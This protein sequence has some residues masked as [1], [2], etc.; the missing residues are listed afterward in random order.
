MR[1]KVLQACTA[2]FEALLNG[3]TRAYTKASS[4]TAYTANCKFEQRE[5]P[6]FFHSKLISVKFSSKGVKRVQVGKPRKSSGRAL[7]VLQRSANSQALLG[8]VTRSFSR[9]RG[10]GFFSRV[11]W[12]VL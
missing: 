2:P 4:R 8:L 9:E 11:L 7:S 3:H 6:L 5:Q 12:G 10:G 1:F